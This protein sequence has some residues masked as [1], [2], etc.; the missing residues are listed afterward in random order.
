MNKLNAYLG[1]A[2]GR[3]ISH[4]IAQKNISQ[5]QLAALSGI[6][7][8]T[9]NAIIQGRRKMTTRQAVTLDRIL[10]FDKGFFAMIQAYHNSAAIPWPSEDKRPVPQ[11]R[12]VVFWDVDINKLSWQEQKDFILSRVEQRGS[13]EEIKQV[14]EY[15]GD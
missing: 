6:Q 9:V 11:I 15:Y 2:P 4:S 14:R 1:I 7:F 13:A 3:I 8:Q 12:P 10:G 5:R